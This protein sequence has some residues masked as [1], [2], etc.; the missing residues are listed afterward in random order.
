MAKPPP[1]KAVTKE[2]TVVLVR[3]LLVDW[4]VL[5]HLQAKGILDERVL[6]DREDAGCCKPDGGTCCVNKRPLR[7]SSV[8]E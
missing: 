4:K 7:E 2:E 8:G 1:T 6:M 3:S 5:E